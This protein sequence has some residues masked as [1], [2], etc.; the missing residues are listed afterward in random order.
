MLQRLKR[1]KLYVKFSKCE[2]WLDKVVFFRHVV[3]T[4]G[5]LVDLN[6]VEAILEWLRP[7]I[8][9]EVRSFLGLVG[10]NRRFIRGSTKLARSFTKLICKDVS[11]K[12]LDVY[13]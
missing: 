11:F 2:F 12:W 8:V 9:T 6:K 13:E 7:K 5:I 3:S 10:Y 1:R 4:K